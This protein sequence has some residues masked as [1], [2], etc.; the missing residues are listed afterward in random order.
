MK[1]SN[2][3]RCATSLAQ[4]R[5]PSPIGCVITHRHPYTPCNLSITKKARIYS[6]AS[7]TTAP[8][9]CHQAAPMATTARSAG[10]ERNSGTRAS[11]SV[12][13]VSIISSLLSASGM[14][15]CM[16]TNC[17]TVLDGSFRWAERGLQFY[18]LRSLTLIRPA[19]RKDD[20]KLLQD[21]LRNNLCVP[22]ILETLEAFVCPVRDVRSGRVLRQFRPMQSSCCMHADAV[23]VLASLVLVIMSLSS[24]WLVVDGTEPVVSGYPGKFCNENGHCK[25]WT[26]VPS[27]DETCGFRGPM[28]IVLGTL[29]PVVFI[30]ALLMLGSCVLVLEDDADEVGPR[31]L[32]PPSGF[33]QCCCMIVLV[34]GAE[35]NDASISWVLL[36]RISRTDDH[37]ACQGRRSN[38]FHMWRGCTR[39]RSCVCCARCSA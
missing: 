39:S 5:F 23:T 18:C 2:I 16:G 20:L 27:G 32:S 10:L 7:S 8:K 15:P 12:A 36:R 35:E 24:P 34:V 37:S 38:I 31:L 13:D 21:M 29:I 11:F 4:P 22:L 17:A 25:L 28:K 33:I 26:S 19:A 9:M 30:K 14:A 6:G 3:A 1:L